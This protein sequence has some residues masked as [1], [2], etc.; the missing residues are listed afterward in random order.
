MNATSS[1]VYAQ[2][3]RYTFHFS[4]P[5]I[6]PQANTTLV[7][8]KGD[9]A[10]YSSHGATDNSSHTFEIATT[11]DV[12]ALG[13]TSNLTTQVQE[14]T[15]AESNP[16]IVLRSTLTASALSIPQTGGKTNSQ[17]IG[18]ITLTANNAGSVALSY[19]KLTFSGNGVAADVAS[20]TGFLGTTTTYTTTDSQTS[21]VLKNSN[22]VDVLSANPGA[23]EQVEPYDGTVEWS[24]P[25]STP[26]VISAGQSLTLQLWGQTNKIP[27]Q[28][29][30]SQSVSVAIQGGNDLTYYDGTDS[31]GLL[32]TPI[33][34]SVNAVPIT[35]SS[36]SWGQG[37]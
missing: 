1:P 2:S 36:L 5:I 21:I 25:T 4:N 23:K 32:S 19:L 22:S 8:L 7:T 37:Q 27:S 20:S 16:Q 34:L 33:G 26:L 24:F 15:T 28:A 11:S 13:A 35:V 10:S 17:Q 31:S 29:N 14:P 18:T 3:Y 12:T 6:V 9:V 30:V